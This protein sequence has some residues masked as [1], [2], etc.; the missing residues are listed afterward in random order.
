MCGGQRAGPSFPDL[1]R[2]QATCLQNRGSKNGQ[3]PQSCS[4]RQCPQ[5]LPSVASSI[6]LHSSPDLTGQS[7]DRGGSGRE[8]RQDSC[9]HSQELSFE[10]LDTF[11]HRHWAASAKVCQQQGTDRAAGMLAEL[12]L[13]PLGPATPERRERDLHRATSSPQPAEASPSVSTLT[14]RSAKMHI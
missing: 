4:V 3:K 5:P 10:S 2:H 6:G 1:S 14:G 13:L 12:A 9:P 7:W 8:G 11:V